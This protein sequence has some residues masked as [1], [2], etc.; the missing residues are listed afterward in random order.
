MECMYLRTWG[1]IPRRKVMTPIYDL[2]VWWELA[3][4]S[5]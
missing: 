5:Y 1:L 3:S 2:G 4:V